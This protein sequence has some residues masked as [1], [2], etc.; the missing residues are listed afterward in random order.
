MPA[1][2]A[3]SSSATTAC[4]CFPGLGNKPQHV[5]SVRFTARELWGQQAMERDTLRLDLFDDY[6]DLAL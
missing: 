6:L 3:A 4:S 1:A 2:N 5:Y